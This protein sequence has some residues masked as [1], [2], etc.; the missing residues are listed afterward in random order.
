MTPNYYIA[1]RKTR[2]REFHARQEFRKRND[3][4][5]FE[6]AWRQYGRPILPINQLSRH[7]LDKS[8]TAAEIMKLK[9]RFRFRG[10]KKVE[11]EG[12]RVV[13]T[14]QRFCPD[15]FGSESYEDQ[16]NKLLS[17]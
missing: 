9:M 1:F 11:R 6:F 13:L 10:W 4:P 15:Y 14:R 17:A 12:K 5:R 8:A 16:N 3:E 7:I 2:K